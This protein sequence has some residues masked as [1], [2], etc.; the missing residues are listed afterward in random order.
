MITADLIRK[1]DDVELPVPGRWGI[2]AQQPVSLRTVGLRRRT[3]AGTM[4]G[5]VSIAEDPADSTL[6]VFISANGTD[7][8]E[9]DLA[10]HATLASA[11]AHGTWRFDGLLEARVAVPVAVDVTYHGVYRRADRALAWLTL[12]ATLPGLGRRPKLVLAAHVNADHPG[13]AA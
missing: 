6:D 12:A 9:Q 7:G 4:S 2:A 11:D 3:I 5:G 10:I 8:A 13:R 1:V